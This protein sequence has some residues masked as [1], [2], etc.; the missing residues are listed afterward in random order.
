MLSS[1]G[2]YLSDAELAQYIDHTLIKP[3]TTEEDVKRVCQEAIQYG[4]KSVC[5]YPKLDLCNGLNISKSLMS[6]PFT[7][8]KNYKAAKAR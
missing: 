3:E 2:G 6:A 8:N 4:F 7:Q 5:L 1:F